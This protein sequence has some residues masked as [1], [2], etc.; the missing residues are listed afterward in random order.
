MSALLSVRNS[1][2][3]PTI[4]TFKTPSFS[5]LFEAC[6]EDHY[7]L[8]HADDSVL[9]SLR[10]SLK[11]DSASQ[12]SLKF[13]ADVERYLNIQCE[14]CLSIFE[15]YEQKELH[16]KT[17]FFHYTLLSTS[18]GEHTAP[19]LIESPFLKRKRA[20]L[21]KGTAR[22]QL[23]KLGTSLFASLSPPTTPPSYKPTSSYR[24][25]TAPSRSVAASAGLPSLPAGWRE[26][27]R[28]KTSTIVYKTN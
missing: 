13:D 12:T 22:Q 1:A 3:P 21:E 9:H 26:I 11:T 6:G 8:L 10:F 17:C 14:S 24:P 2:H 4:K 5:R 27:T 23:T 15:S 25:T 19:S 18:Y 16:T 28:K 7:R 20:I